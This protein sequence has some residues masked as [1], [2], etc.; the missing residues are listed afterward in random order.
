MLRILRWG[1][2]PSNNVCRPRVITG[3]F[4]R[5]K[6]EGKSQKKR[7]NNSHRGG[8]EYQRM[9]ERFESLS[10]WPQAKDSGGL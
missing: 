3:V 5:G 8:R 10:F 4:I 1:G 7:Q 6:Q 2:Y 9:R